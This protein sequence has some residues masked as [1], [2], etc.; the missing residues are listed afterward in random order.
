[1][2]HVN[3]IR[4]TNVNCVVSLNVFSQDSKD[5]I[6][7][8]KELCSKHNIDVA[9]NYGYS[10]GSEGA[11]DLANLVIDKLNQE[12]ITKYNYNLDDDL[13]TKINNI[14]RN[15]Y[16]GNGFIVKEEVKDK[17][18]QIK[19]SKLDDYF[20]CMAK[21]PKS[22]SDDES[23]LNAPNDFDITITDFKV[24]HGSKFIICYANKIMTMP[25]LNK[26]PNATKIKYHDGVIDNLS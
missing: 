26:E 6:N 8:F 11:L 20:I 5:E 12:S 22:F 7:T 13:D 18:E 1:M 17:Y 15:V 9:I 24:C 19:Q 16:G 3:N 23:L 21:T 10:Q 4:N 14:I 25:G 2:R